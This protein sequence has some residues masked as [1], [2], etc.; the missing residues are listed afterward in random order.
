MFWKAAGTL[1][2][3]AVGAYT[4][5][6]LDNPFAG[7]IGAGIGAA[8]AY[9]MVYHNPIKPLS[10]KQYSF[11]YD[12]DNL[13]VNSRSAHELD[14]AQRRIGVFKSR[15]NKIK[16]LEAAILG[17]LKKQIPDSKKIKRNYRTFL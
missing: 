4:Q 9:S 5:D 8:A 6:P 2:G 12:K 14:K 16:S 3:A 15:K 1:T 13:S 10:L 11:K 7:I 17:E